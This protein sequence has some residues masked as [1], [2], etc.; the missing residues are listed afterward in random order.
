M[1]ASTATLS[2]VT[3]TLLGGFGTTVKLFALTLLFALPLGLLLSFGT[4]N[5]WQPFGNF[6]GNL[7][8]DIGKYFC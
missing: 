8:P 2:S 3:L 4:M 5:K 7:L 1:S 6:C